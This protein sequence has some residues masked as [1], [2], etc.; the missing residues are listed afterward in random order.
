MRM[1]HLSTNLGRKSRLRRSPHHSQ[2]CTDTLLQSGVYKV[3]L[4][5]ARENSLS[6]AYNLASALVR[7]HSNAA[8]TDGRQLEFPTGDN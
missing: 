1:K 5:F 2:S 6:D 3:D 7:L 8:L 4:G